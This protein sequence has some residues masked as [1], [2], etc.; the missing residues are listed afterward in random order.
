[1][2]SFRLNFL[3]LIY[4]RIFLGIECRQITLDIIEAKNPLFC[5]HSCH[6][7]YYKMVWYIRE[8]GLFFE[9]FY[10]IM[11]HVVYLGIVSKKKDSLLGASW[12]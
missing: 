10:N 11:F 12:H 1:M 3:L 6:K 2:F 7:N 4:I 9:I 8:M 5:K